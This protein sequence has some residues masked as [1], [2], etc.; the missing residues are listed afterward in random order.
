M[1][2]LSEQ[3]IAE[4]QQRVRH[5]QKCLDFMYGQ[6]AQAGKKRG[7]PGSNQL[8]LRLFPSPYMMHHIS[9]FIAERAHMHAAEGR[10]IRHMPDLLRQLEA[11]TFVRRPDLSRMPLACEY[12]MGAMYG[13]TVECFRM[14]CLDKGGRLKE[15]VL[16]NMGIFDASIFSLKLM[17]Q[18][19]DRVN[20]AAVI[21]AHNHPAGTARPSPEDLDCTA[22]ALYALTA[23][24]IP[25]LDHIIVCNDCCISI[26]SNGFIGERFWRNQN[27]NSKLLDNWLSTENMPDRTLNRTGDSYLSFGTAPE[28]DDDEI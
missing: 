6:L 3:E 5:F 7:A 20:P 10:L 25:M 26:R 9:P 11:S 21:L 13:L 16:L 14:L 23:V 12:L 8:M 4:E 2:R 17:L 15:D 22:E 1:A 19:I 18:E 24:G 28:N 27:Q